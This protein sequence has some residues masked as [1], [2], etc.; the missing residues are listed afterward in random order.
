MRASLRFLH[1][2]V[3]SSAWFLYVGVVYSETEAT[4][5]T[6]I[7]N[8]AI[9]RRSLLKSI[10]AL[11]AGALFLKTPWLFAEQLTLTPRQTEGPYYPIQLPLDT[12]NDLV[13]R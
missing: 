11:G 12:D 6:T 10:G 9:G 3:H 13:C 5:T 1:N 4:M 8:A 2:S 7:W